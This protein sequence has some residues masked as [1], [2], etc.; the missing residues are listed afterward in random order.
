MYT[1][2][3]TSNKLKIT[4]EKALTE[5]ACQGVTVGQTLDLT[6][7]EEFFFLPPLIY[8]AAKCTTASFIVPEEGSFPME[9]QGI[10]L[11]N[12]E[13]EATKCEVV[14]VDVCAVIYPST[15]SFPLSH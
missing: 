1:R 14:S 10:V 3:V 5:L 7:A 11:T 15:L 13:Q 4:G 2:K 9:F 12:P 8:S 6:N